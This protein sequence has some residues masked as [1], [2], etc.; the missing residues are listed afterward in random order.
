K[1][2]NKQVILATPDEVYWFFRKNVKFS[3]LL[4]Y[5]LAMVD[6]FVLDEAHL[7]I[8]LILRN[9]AHLKERV[10]L[11]SAKLGRK[12]LWHILTATPT[13]GLREL[14]GG[15]EVRG[16]S[17]CGN[18]EVS[19]LEPVQGYDERQNRLV[20]A[21][22]TALADGAR[23]VLLV[24]NSADLAHR[25]FESIKGRSRPDMP[26]DLQWRFGRI[27]W[28]KFKPWLEQEAGE[29]EQ[30]VEEIERWLGTE[31]PLYLK[32]LEAGTQCYVP[33]ET[34]AAR[35]AHLL[36]GQ[37]W[38]IKRLL[39]SAARENGHDFIEAVDRRL[40]GQGKLPRLLWRTLEP[41][42]ENRA[43]PERLFG[44]LEALISL[45]QEGLERV[46]ADEAL[47]VTAPEFR[48]I[49]ASLREAGA[50]HELAEA[51]TVLLKDTM[52]IP[53][54]AAAGLRMSAKE[55]CQRRLAFPWLKWLIKEQSIREA[56]VERIRQAMAE[57]RLEFETRHIALWRDIGVPVV[58][59]TGKMRRAERKGLIEAFAELPRSVLISTSAVEV[60][61]DFDADVLIT[62]QCDGN[63]FLQRF[64][65]VGR[66]L[67]SHCKVIA[68]VRDGD[69]YIRLFH[70][71]QAQ[72]SREEFS[73][74]IADPTEGIFPARLHAEGSAF[75][76]ATHW[77]VNTQLGEIGDS[78]NQSMFGE[79]GV[80][81]L[82]LKLRATGLPFVYGLRGTL[83]EVTLQGG[84][85]GEPFYILRKVSNERLLPGDSPF[86]MARSDMWYM[87]FL[88]KLASWKAIVVDIN[89][90]L[91]GSHALFWWK[92]GEWHTQAGYGIAAD[93]LKLF[94]DQPVSQGKSLP[95]LLNA[96]KPTITENL[97]G[98][99]SEM[100]AQQSKPLPRLLLRVGKA[101]RLFFEP[102][103]RFILGQGQ[104]YLKRVD[105]D[106]IALAVEDRFGNPL[107]L[108]DQMWLLLYGHTKDET[109]GRLRTVSALD[110]QEVI[111]DFQTLDVQGS[112]II[113]PVLLDRVAGACFDVYRK[114]VEHVA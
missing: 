86:E 24:F 13:A 106:G 45:I 31:R 63:G 55:L 46:W 82:A 6:E 47:Q 43:N 75:L 27:Q 23:K 96:V 90:T 88:W 21:V 5:G 67:G 44:G 42:L 37:A 40:G 15:I 66:R 65:R 109:E 114:L 17:K 64:G 9:L 83:P 59:Y 36:E 110:W 70:R 52:E 34:L 11:L 100:N 94:S 53:E 93:Y 62:E 89:A 80:K 107:V 39:N 85:G 29:F 28:G 112:R 33:T 8:G 2:L 105:P 111:Y 79:S 56:L 22:D 69:T 81:E 72:M 48:E 50:G 77:L 20:T 18:I 3:G 113:G 95:Q 76:D 61:V 101:L 49:T 30:I 73:S 58:V 103:H 60:G 87:K 1:A 97:D 84:G 57:N 68:L 51:I 4:I 74:L 32:D 91:E 92:D 41:G 99:L 14:A 78:L 12:S 7:F 26:I 98:F 16:T 35:V 38:I 25:V 19:F 104:V 71:H 108:Q 10:R 54:N 102:H